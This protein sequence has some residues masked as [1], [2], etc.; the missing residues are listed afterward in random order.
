MYACMYK[1]MHYLLVVVSPCDGSHAN[2]C[3][4]ETDLFM[5]FCLLYL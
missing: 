1:Y 2:N 3:I 5:K 4:G